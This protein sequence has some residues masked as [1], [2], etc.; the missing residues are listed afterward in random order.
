MALEDS[1][2]CYSPTV[3]SNSPALPNSPNSFSRN[4]STASSPA[5]V[6]DIKMNSK[7]GLVVDDEDMDI[8]VDDDDDDS[9]ERNYKRKSD[10][11]NIG[12]FSFSI[13][14][15]LS[16][17][18]GPKPVKI[19]NDHSDRLFRPFEIRD[20][21]CNNNSNNSVNS[22]NNNKMFNPSSVFLNSFKLSE[23]FDYST[24]NLSSE[25]QYKSSDNSFRNSLYN[26][27]TSYPKI[28]DEFLNNSNNSN[29]HKKYSSQV[30]NNSLSS[31][32]SLKIPSSIGGLCKTISQ[33]GQDSSPQSLST[34]SSSLKSSCTSPTS[35]Q[36]KS[37]SSDTLKLPQSSV[38]SM[39]LDSDDCQSE[40]S[41]D[42]NKMWPAWI[43][44]TR[45]SDRP[46]SGPRY[47]RP[48]E[49]KEKGTDDEKRPRTAFSN[50]QLL[51][52]K[53]EF[54]ENRYLT[55]KRRHQLSAELGLNEAQIKIWF[56][57]KRAK[58]KKTSGVKNS[59]AIQLMAQGLYNHTT[60]P[61]T[62]EEEE[63]ELRMNGNFK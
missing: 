28:H 23:I 52:L 35:F 47:R 4:S 50:E 34:S 60:V 53:K 25:N 58:I 63:L 62:K 21:I 18:F 36:T 43:F 17:N 7:H 5:T 6:C 32:S 49:K 20:F 11:L 51:R 27:F 26:N 61:L 56:Q 10:S 48:K 39:S 12:K 29:N 9:Y 16:D 1:R 22:N 42:D 2:Y 54:N 45:Y 59:L 24:K 40:A 8:N 3:E 37:N 14:N 33:I 19:E 44:C 57:N 30:T 13:T 55:E 31:A 38:D 41:K 46:S 15:I